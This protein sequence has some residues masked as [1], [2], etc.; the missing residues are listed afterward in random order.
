MI[1][2]KKRGDYEIITFAVREPLLGILDWYCKEHNTNR[3]TAIRELLTQALK[4]KGYSIKHYDK[5]GKVK[6][7]VF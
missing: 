5:D 3:S 4:N 2:T 1:K 6:K 7:E